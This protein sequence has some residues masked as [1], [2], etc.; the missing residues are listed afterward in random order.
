MDGDAPY[1]EH[2]VSE[3]T[4]QLLFEASNS[5]NLKKSLEILIQNAKSDSGRLELSSKRILPAVLHIVHSLTHASPHHHRNHI[6]SLCFKLL[7]NLCAGETVNLG[8]FLEHNGVAA[9]Y[10][11]LRSEASSS[12]PDHALV[13]WGLQ[14]LANVSLA[15]K[16]HQR[17]ILDELYPIGFKSLARASTKET[18]DPLCM[19]IYTCCDGNPEWFKKLSS[20]DGWPI[21]EEIVRTV[22]FGK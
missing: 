16:Q 9:V 1:S 5:S 6:L 19:V 11:V 2:L 22:S 13:C 10:S 8:L 3:D 18:C 12:G 7:R 4:L 21:L 15:G 20:D 17:A 14:V